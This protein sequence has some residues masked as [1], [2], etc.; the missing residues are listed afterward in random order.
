MANQTNTSDVFQYYDE[1]A[2]AQRQDKTFFLNSFL[3]RATAD[4]SQSK[5]KPEPPLTVF[6]GPSRFQAVLIADNSRAFRKKDDSSG[7]GF[8][9]SDPEKAAILSKKSISANIP[10]TVVDLIAMNTRY[11]Y[12]KHLDAVYSGSEAREEQLSPA[13]TLM[14][15]VGK[16][17]KQTPAELLLSNPNGV[18]IAK[19]QIS[20]L[21]AN[22]GRYPRNQK[23]IDALNEGIDLYNRGLLNKNLVRKTREI[24][25]YQAELR[26]LKSEKRYKGMWFVYD[27]KIAWLVGDESPVKI[28]IMNYYAPV[29]ER[30]DRTYNVLKGKMDM[31]TNRGLSID[32]LADEWIRCVSAMQRNMLQFTV[33]N[34]KDCYNERNELSKKAVA[35]SMRR[36]NGA[37]APSQNPSPYGGQGYGAQGRPAGTGQGQYPSQNRSYQNQPSPQYNAGGGS[38]YQNAPSGYAGQGTRPAQNADGAV[39]AASRGYNYQNQ[40]SP[41]YNAGGRPGYQNAPSGYAG[42]G[43]RPAQNADGAVNAASRGYNY[44]NQPSPQYNAGGK[45]GYQ[46]APSEYAGQGTRPAQNYG[47]AVQNRA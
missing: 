26:P 10:A 28:S 33:N 30:E 34:G 43:T 11:A 24:V 15:N 25:L 22:L 36:Q 21:A 45:S 35:E 42:Q 6:S 44:Q 13:Y 37:S 23:Q 8:G 46:N 20:F 18:E 12:E 9:G 4:T 2:V 29:D 19:R 31:E 3:S 32:L 41:Q 7:G 39:N 1:V 17:L 47:N 14:V 27:I 16:N 5:R 40:P 38:R